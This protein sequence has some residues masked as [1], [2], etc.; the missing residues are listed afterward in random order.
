MKYPM[1]YVL[2]TRQEPHHP[3]TRLEQNGECTLLM[4][5]GE[6]VP[7]YPP[8]VYRKKRPFPTQEAQHKTP[9]KRSHAIPQKECDTNKRAVKHETQHLSSEWSGLLKSSPTF[10]SS[11]SPRD[12][13]QQ[14][15]PLRRGEPSKK[16]LSNRGQS[17]HDLWLIAM[18]I[19]DQ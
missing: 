3:R 17:G 16:Y 4:C 6:E 10:S 8:V 9:N 13:W 18:Y 15:Q 19:Q 11:S 12:A 14:T 7:R 2:S 1:L 5:L